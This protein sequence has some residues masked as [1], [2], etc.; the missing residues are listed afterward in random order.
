MTTTSTPLP[1]KG[2]SRGALATFEFRQGMMDAETYAGVCKEEAKSKEQER[3]A[4]ALK[5]AKYRHAAAMRPRIAGQFL[6]VPLANIYAK[7]KIRAAEHKRL[8]DGG[9]TGTGWMF[10]DESACI[11][12]RKVG[13]PKD[14]PDRGIWFDVGALLL[15]LTDGQAYTVACAFDLT[16]IQLAR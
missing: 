5:A 9:Y 14:H 16:T 4:K 2:Q 12:C 1:V 15:G 7:V 11:R 3:A 8:K 6:F 13:L 10:D